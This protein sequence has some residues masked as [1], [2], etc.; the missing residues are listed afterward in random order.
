MKKL[1]VLNLD[2]YYE[3]TDASCFAYHT[4]YLMFAER[5]RSSLVK[6]EFPKL[7]ELMI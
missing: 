1:H 5:A 6:D 7:M 4:T 3:D 2:V